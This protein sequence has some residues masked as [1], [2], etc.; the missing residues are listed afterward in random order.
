MAAPVGVFIENISF[1][2]ATGAKVDADYDNDGG[3]AVTERG[4]VWNLTGTPTIADTKIVGPLDGSSS[5]QTTMT[6]LP[7]NTDIYVR[8]YATNANG[9]SYG[10]WTGHPAYFRTDPAVSVTGSIPTS[11]AASGSAPSSVAVTGSI[12]TANTGIGSIPLTIAGSDGIVT[13]IEV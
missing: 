13:E 2:T 12:P 1:I 7:P 3:S 5:Y 8:A 10:I 9:T 6:G 4:V 11:L